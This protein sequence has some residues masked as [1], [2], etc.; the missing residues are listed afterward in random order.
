MRPNIAALLIVFLVCGEIAL[1]Q[2]E[3][4]GNVTEA[5]TVRAR[6]YEPLILSAARRYQIDPHL[7]WTIA[8]L[9][10]RFRN[11]AVSYKNGKP[12][13]YGMMQFTIPTAQRYGLVNPHDPQQAID[14]AAR[15]VRDLQ[16][17]FGS[18]AEL[19]LAAYNAGEGTVEAFRE[20][21]TLVWQ[22][23]VIN[24]RGIRTGGIPPYQETRNYVALGS[25][26][27][28]NRTRATAVPVSIAK[29]AQQSPQTKSLPTGSKRQDSIYSLDH[30]TQHTNEPSKQLGFV[31]TNSLYVN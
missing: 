24:P 30:P 9:E 5:V 10:S 4:R 27:Y 8:Y 2:R 14:A 17:R 6:L 12:C 20:G 25:L 11:E 29:D 26:V 22:N 18:R 23:K 3:Q 15:Y 16:K 1:A 21:K 13:A 19:I 7:L 28:S 31:K